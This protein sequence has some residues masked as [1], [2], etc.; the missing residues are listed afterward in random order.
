MTWFAL[1][2]WAWQTTGQATTL[3]LVSFFAFIPTLLFSP[4]A[5][6][7]VD[8]WNRKWVMILSDFGAAV[9]TFI[10]LLLH[11]TNSLQIWHLYIVGAVG[12]VFLALQ[13]P[14]YS[15]A[16][17][18]VLPKEHYARAEG[19]IETGQSLAGILA[20]LLA[21]TLLGLIHL[22]GILLID[23]FTFLIALATLLWVHLPEPRVMETKRTHRESLWQATL[24]GFR[25]IFRRRSLVALQTI[26]FCG[27]L[28]E[29]SGYTLIAPMLLARTHNNE[30]MLGSVQSVG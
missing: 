29:A 27:N 21:A 24:Y 2:L 16:L 11:I 5:G 4:L 8:R 22:T 9:A 30:L 10:V 7:L 17:T 20:P 12:G 14:A 6:A 23:L 18:L 26:F 15:A 28:L 19:M 13:F 25:Y 1:T 3:A